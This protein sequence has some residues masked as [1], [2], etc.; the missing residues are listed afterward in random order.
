VGIIC[1]SILFLAFSRFLILRNTFLNKRRI[2]RAIIITAHDDDAVSHGRY[3]LPN[4]RLAHGVGSLK[5]MCFYQ[6]EEG[7]YKN[8]ESSILKHVVKLQGWNGVE[9]HEPLVLRDNIESSKFLEAFF[10]GAVLTDCINTK[11]RKVI[12]RNLF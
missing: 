2:K 11:K 6:K 8:L 1:F 10:Q 5:Q 7:T 12:L 9:H 4:W 3:Y